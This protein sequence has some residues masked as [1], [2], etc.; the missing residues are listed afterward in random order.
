MS[1]DTVNPPTPAWSESLSFVRLLRTANRAVAF[2]PMTLAF[3]L[4]L[5]GCLAGRALDGV[6]T[7]AGAGLIVSGD[8]TEIHAYS[9]GSGAFGRW[10]RDHDRSA[11]DAV[12]KGPFAALLS[13]QMHCFSAAVQ[14]VTQGSFSFAGSAFSPRPAL[15]GSVGSAVS[16]LL[17]FATQRTWFAI[18]YGLVILVLMA[19]FG[20]AICRIAAVR[21]TRRENLS[22][23]EAL[24]FARQKLLDSILA[25]LW[26]L[27]IFGG[28]A[29][30]MILGSLVGAIP[31][32]G[33]F[34]A[35]LTYGIA[36][37]G[38]M[39]LVFS[40]VVFALGTHLM[41]PTLAVEGSDHFDAVQHGAGYVIQR[42]WSFAW[43]SI[44]LMIS[45]AL[46]FLLVR[47]VLLLLLKM[48]HSVTSV[49]MSFFGA[50][51]SSGQEGLPKLD[52]MWHMP[53][54]S[55][56]R[57]LP[58]DNGPKFWGDFAAAAGPLSGA[59]TFGMWLLMFWVFVVVGLLAAFVVSFY[60]CGCT[61]MYL[62]M[63]REIDAVDYDEMFYEE[64]DDSDFDEPAAEP[65]KPDG[66]TSL[67]VVGGS[68]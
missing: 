7:R 19:I 33:E 41:A 49:G 32:I 63:R 56:L 38:G 21:S 11:E 1:E 55:N 22:G 17:W 2:W 8:R 48:T 26:P 47:G 10:V 27:V 39:A 66:G 58:G 37:V 24:R 29:V 6:W 20:T 60:F 46:S 35:G 3:V 52:G 5:S 4:V 30:L 54:W 45:G 64:F 65:S 13:Y 28:A 68:E 67:P 50:V 14:G 16:G 9:Q 57:M 42:P 15:L 61:E 62:V 31:V 34:I 44:V 36:L 25:P 53:D 12:F 40:A 18:V 23:I 51:S 43:Y 59:E